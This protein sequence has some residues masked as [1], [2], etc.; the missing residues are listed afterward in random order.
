MVGDFLGDSR[1]LRLRRLDGKADEGEGS[2][3][4]KTADEGTA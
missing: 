1:L 4:G 3:N 2:E